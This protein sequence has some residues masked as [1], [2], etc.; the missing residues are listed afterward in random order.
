M[1]GRG[2]GGRCG[3]WRGGRING[4][5]E[6]QSS[7]RGWCAE[8]Q[9]HQNR[10]WSMAGLGLLQGNTCSDTHCG[11]SS[12]Y[13]VRYG[14]QRTYLAWIVHEVYMTD[15][16]PRRR[17]THGSSDTS[18]T[19]RVTGADFSLPRC[20]R[21][22][23]KL[24]QPPGRSFTAWLKGAWSLDPSATGNRGSPSHHP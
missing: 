9:H 5:A 22:L 24:V 4:E 12:S 7:R 13:S 1:V 21:V 19:S 11:M 17:P 23:N 16:K 10:G 18:N 6:V 8:Q 14:P 2:R 3:P 15:S 20:D